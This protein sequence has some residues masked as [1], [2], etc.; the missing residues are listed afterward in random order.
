MAFCLLD[1]LEYPRL[2]AVNIFLWVNSKY[3]LSNYPH[4]VEKCSTTFLKGGVK[5]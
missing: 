1:C 2:K 5:Q 4:G 3:N